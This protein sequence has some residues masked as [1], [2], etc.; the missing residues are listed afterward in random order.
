MHQ[1]RIHLANL[2]ASISGDAYYGGRPFFLSS[3]KRN[4]NLKKDTDEQPLI[5]RHALH[6]YELTFL[7]L[8]D[9]KITVKADY[10]KDFRVLVEQLGKN[11]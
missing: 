8:E 11:V 9:E 4:Y 6:A 5:K 10:P 7:S 1:I 3:V 2:G